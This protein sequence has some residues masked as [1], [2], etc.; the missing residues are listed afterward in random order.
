MKHLN[1][2]KKRIFLP[3]LIGSFVSA[4]ALC[5]RSSIAQVNL[6]GVGNAINADNQIQPAGGVDTPAGAGVTL[7]FN[8]A[9]G[10]LTIGAGGGFEIGADIQIFDLDNGAAFD[11]TITTNAGNGSI[12]L[13]GDLKGSGQLLINGD[14]TLGFEAINTFTGTTRIATNATVFISNG[15]HLKNIDLDGGFLVIRGE[16]DNITNQGASTIALEGGTAS[17][18]D[19]NATRVNAYLDSTLK[20]INKFKDLGF[21]FPV[22]SLTFELGKPGESIATLQGG[23]VG[24]Q[25]TNARIIADINNTSSKEG[26]WTLLSAKGNLPEFAG[27]QLSYK[28][29]IKLID[30]NQ[31]YTSAFYKFN[32]ETVNLNVPTNGNIAANGAD[33]DDT[34]QLTIS[35]NTG[36]NTVTGES[37]NEN[38]ETVFQEA[39]DSIWDGVDRG[40]LDMNYF[41]SQDQAQK[42]IGGLTPPNVDAASNSLSRLNNALATTVLANQSPVFCKY[43]KTWNAWT[44]GFGGNLNVDG[45]STHVLNDYNSRFGGAMLGAN[46]RINNSFCVGGFASNSYLN[47]NQDSSSLVGS[48][49]WD[50]TGWGGGLAATYQADKHYIQGMFGASSFSGDQKRRVY[51]TA[52]LINEDLSSKTLTGDKNVTSYVT[53]LKFGAPIASGD[54]I[55]EPQIQAAWIH[56]NENSFSESGSDIRRINYSGRSTDFFQGEVGAK[57][58]YPMA[59]SKNTS[60]IPNLRVAWTNNTRLSNTGQE[61]DYTFS[62]KKTSLKGDTNPTMGALIEGGVDYVIANT[63]STSYK[64]YANGGIE[65]Q[66]QGSANWRAS[67]GIT[68]S[69]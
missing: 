25:T 49:S 6:G 59:L 39:L 52:G 8:D 19:A 32:L 43:T 14:G 46:Y 50:A 66:N 41:A 42:I 1:H 11:A 44:K 54:F 56:N 45:D 40:N 33:L 47:V 36:L 13:N 51:A 28:G 31:I 57:V 53:A 37:F 5:P 30:T 16:A 24:N 3:I 55:I 12:S 15:A 62:N 27:F 48:G 64:L 61:I 9:D 26:T 2:P 23:F 21:F 69:F 18:I 68:I 34:I 20:G 58:T 22:N 65:F 38:D 4:I 63:D 35:R 67:G 10:S 17:G 60:L 29:V 7:I